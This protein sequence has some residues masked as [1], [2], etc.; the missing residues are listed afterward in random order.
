[1]I[2]KGNR[3]FINYSLYDNSDWFNYKLTID[4]IVD[5]FIS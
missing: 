2:N 1:M 4:F 5:Y 3:I